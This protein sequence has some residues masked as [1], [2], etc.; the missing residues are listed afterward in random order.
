MAHRRR[1]QRDST[2][3]IM[4]QNKTVI[5][6]GLLLLLNKL[7]QLKAVKDSNSKRDSKP[8]LSAVRRPKAEPLHPH[9]TQGYLWHQRQLLRSRLPICLKLLILKDKLLQSL[10][11]QRPRLRQESLFLDGS[12]CPRPKRK[13]SL[14]DRLRQPQAV[15]P[16]LWLLLRRPL[17]LRLFSN[18]S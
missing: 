11:C 16:I 2:I 18:Q 4:T 8:S 7:E 9:Q 10:K 5:K 14:L 12:K 17:E 13:P 15:S 6:A 3:L 1:E